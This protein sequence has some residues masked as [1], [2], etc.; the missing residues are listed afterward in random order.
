MR[1]AIRLGLPMLD[2]EMTEAILSFCPDR[3]QRTEPHRCGEPPLS[4]PWHTG[5]LY[6]RSSGSAVDVQIL[7]QLLHHYNRCLRYGP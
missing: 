5:G 3:L 6:P 4:I 2:P 1:R 7:I